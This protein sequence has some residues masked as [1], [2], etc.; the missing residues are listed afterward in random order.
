MGQAGHLLDAL[1]QAL[2]GRDGRVEWTKKKLQV[3][4]KFRV[5]D[6]FWKFVTWRK[7]RAHVTQVRRVVENYEP[8]TSKILIYDF[9]MPLTN[10]E[11]LRLTLDS[12]F[13]KDRVLAR[14]KTIGVAK[15]TEEF[16]KAD[17]AM[18]D[19]D[20]Y[21]SALKFIQDHFIG[22]SIYHVNGRFRSADL[23]TQAAAAELQTKGQRYLIGETTAITRFIFPYK[24][25]AELKSVRYFFQALFIRSIIQLVN[26]EEQI[27]MVETGS[28][29]S[30]LHIWERLGDD[31]DD[32]DDDDEDDEEE[33]E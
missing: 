18:S 23:L 14:L 27:W 20:Y 9:L 8:K 15:L 28:A 19:D 1:P 25:D 22:Y 30:Q 13:F 29:G 5:T 2:Q 16:A 6:A 26:G 32:A 7:F 4:D 17:P 3:T 11:H 24:T 10:E 21:A 31:E 12:L 33:G